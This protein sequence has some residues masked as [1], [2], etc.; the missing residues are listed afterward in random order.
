[1]SIRNYN[2]LKSLNLCSTYLVELYLG[3]GWVETFEQIKI[4]LKFLL[5]GIWCVSLMWFEAQ[6]IVKNKVLTNFAMH[7][8]FFTI[9]EHL[10]I[11]KMLER[12]QWW[13]AASSNLRSYIYDIFSLF[14]VHILLTFAK[15]Q[16]WNFWPLIS[17]TFCKQ[18]S[19]IKPRSIIFDSFECM[20][21]EPLH[22]MA[23]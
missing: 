22:D 19:S 16:L 7:T 4:K 12:L 2:K 13:F 14:P 11:L 15:A 3:I 23:S 10:S 18:I 21:N 1:M 6:L 20:G 8:I 5:L 17:S 9:L